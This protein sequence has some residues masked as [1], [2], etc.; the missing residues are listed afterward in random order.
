MLVS[1]KQFIKERF[2]DKPGRPDPATVRRWI[3]AG[4]LP[5]KII[6]ASYYVEIDEESAST[7]NSLADSVLRAT[8]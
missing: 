8:R 4:H 2:G 5:G 3:R 7:G 1:P 6:G